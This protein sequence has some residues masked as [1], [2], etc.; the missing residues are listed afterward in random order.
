VDSG[1]ARADVAEGIEAPFRRR[2]LPKDISPAQAEELM[3]SQVGNAPLRD[4]AI[5][6]LLY[7]T[8]VRAAEVVGTNLDDV[9]F[10]TQT[11]RVRGKGNKER[12][13]VFGEPCAAAL[14][15]Y[16][17]SERG[18][19]DALFT[20]QSGKRISARTIQ[21]I[22]ERRRGLVGLSDDATP[23]SLRHSF[24]THLL[25]GG[26]DLKTVQQLLGHESLTTTQVYTHVSV[27]R[28]RDVVAKK[29]PKG[30]RK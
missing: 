6:E 28:L 14:S 23:H 30:R 18:P 15:D 13:V 1:F 4:R 29:H 26:A 11:M 20:G 5:L 8:G 21:R 7:G 12:I 19:G 25:N 10:P 27:E 24:A 3:E 17:S 2:G 22:I 9:D 16:I